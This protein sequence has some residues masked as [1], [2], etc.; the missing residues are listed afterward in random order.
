MKSQ[1]MAQ[2][3]L[4]NWQTLRELTPWTLLYEQPIHGKIL[5]VELIGGP[6]I[7]VFRAEDGVFYFC[8]GLTFGGK[9]A[10]GGA[11]SPFSGNDVRTILRC[12]YAA[13]VPDAAAR[14]GDILVWSGLDNDAPHSA[15]LTGPTVE[16]GKSY[17]S[18]SSKIL[19]KN[20]RLPE[21]EMTLERLIGDEFSYGDS[22]RLFRKN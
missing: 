2:S 20:G 16:Q 13:V 15:I 14:E 18:Y 4:F 5:E 8:H 3:P 10:P 12:S 6:K 17:L 9:A 21:E 7:E 22:F 1:L 11:V 19:T